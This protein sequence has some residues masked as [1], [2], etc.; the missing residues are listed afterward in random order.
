M[1]MRRAIAF[2]S[3]S[4]TAF[5]HYSFGTGMCYSFACL[6]LDTSL[7][8]KAAKYTK[9]EESKM[10]TPSLILFPVFAGSDIEQVVVKL[11]VL[12]LSLSRIPYLPYQAIPYLPYQALAA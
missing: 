6:G 9:K 1:A 4:A 12:G 11:K 7:A 3:C 8:N 2:R 10:G 5:R